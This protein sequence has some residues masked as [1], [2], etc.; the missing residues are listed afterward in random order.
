MHELARMV[1]L[2]QHRRHCPACHHRGNCLA[3]AAV[4]SASGWPER[5]IMAKGKYS[6]ATLIPMFRKASALRNEMIAAGFTDNGGAIHSC[7]R[8][9][10]IL[11]QRVKYP[12]LGHINNF[13]KSNRAVF[14]VAAL[15]AFKKKGR[16]L[17]EHVAPIRALT[18]AAI[19]LVTRGC[20]DA[21]L[22]AFVKRK[23]RL[24]LLTPT[25]TLHLNKVN[26]SRMTTD[27]LK[28]SGIKLAKSSGRRRHLK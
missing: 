6:P 19:D 3:R 12:G 1:Q 16:V 8:I 28:R 26:R 17:I 10:D 15:A 21:E 4:S 7:E 23:Y 2:A 14:S 27:R 5:D 20:S 22:I 24:D 25:E 13:R 9:L 18:R 11:G